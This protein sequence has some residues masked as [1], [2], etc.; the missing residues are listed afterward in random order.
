MCRIRKMTLFGTSRYATMSSIT[1]APISTTDEPYFLTRC[2]L[3]ANKRLEYQYT[4]LHCSLSALASRSPRSLSRNSWACREMEAANRSRAGWPTGCP[5]RRR[6][7]FPIRS[8]NH[9]CGK[10]RSPN[11]SASCRRRDTS[12]AHPYLGA[13]DDESFRVGRLAM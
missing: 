5:I 10:R 3:S 9:Q 8:G 1:R 2:S 12:K 6:S 4:L 11:R 13:L 7:A